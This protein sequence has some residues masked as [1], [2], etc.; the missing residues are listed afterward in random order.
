M[1]AL[2]AEY[3]DM[4]SAPPEN[5]PWYLESPVAFAEWAEA[6][7]VPAELILSDEQVRLLQEP[8]PTFLNGPAGSGKTTLALYRLLVI[9]E[10]DPD[11]DIA[12]V[13]HNPRL[14]AHARDL[15][16]ALPFRPEETA[17]VD[18]KTYRELAAET[19]GMGV[20]DLQH[21]QVPPERLRRFLGRHPLSSAEQQLYATDIR[22]VVKGMLPLQKNARARQ[23]RVR[24]VAPRDLLQRDA[25]YVVS[26][27]ASQAERGVS[28]GRAVP[29]SAA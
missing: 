8:L 5:L 26:G 2:S 3:Q 23:R 1:L 19:M 25:G 15:Y 13:T 14:V 28:P 27:A 9:Q 24:L 16:D 18:F 17:P 22:A 6:E 29:R 21:Y 7:E 11:A 4:L 20:S 10:N 12:F